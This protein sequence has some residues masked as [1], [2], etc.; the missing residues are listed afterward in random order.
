M[1][2]F[3]QADPVGYYGGINLYSYVANN[4]LNYVDPMGLWSFRVDWYE[5]AGGSIIFG[6]NPDGR[7]FYG[8]RIGK[9]LG[10]GVSFNPKGKTPGKSCNKESGLM[11]MDLGFYA[12]A[13][14]NLLIFSFGTGM[15]FG[16]HAQ[17]YPSDLSIYK[18]FN[19]PGWNF[20]WGEEMGIRGSVSTGVEFYLY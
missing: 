5:G 8:G 14:V 13:S 3:L 17:N 7:F 6:R 20:S 2:R 4:P 19:P 15:E 1:G 10:K 12:D 9:G 18:N 11:N 16:G